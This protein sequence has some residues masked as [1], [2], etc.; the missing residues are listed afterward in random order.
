MGLDVCVHKLVRIPDDV[1]T[2]KQLQ[3]FCEDNKVDWEWY[4]DR[5]KNLPKEYTKIVK[6][7][8]VDWK[9][10]FAQK[11]LDS[12]DYECFGQC[13]GWMEFVKKGH[14]PSEEEYVVTTSDFAKFFFHYKKLPIFCYGEEVG[15]QRKGANGRFYKDGKW[16][17][18]VI[19]TTHEMLTDDWVKYFS[20]EDDDYY[21]KEARAHFK[22]H[23]I[24]NFVEGETFVWYC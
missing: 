17:K 20:D 16:D 18:N 22:E 2:Q 4:K 24:D 19:V 7:R 10:T 14:Q 3:K 8:L 6:F 13:G 5:H 15:W 12:D 1:Q 9:K 23:I 11:G 21:G